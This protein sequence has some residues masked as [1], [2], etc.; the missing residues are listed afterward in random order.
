MGSPVHLDIPPLHSLCSSEYA[1][2]RGHTASH[3]LQ[4][5]VELIAQH[6]YIHLRIHDPNVVLEQGNLGGIQ[7]MGRCEYDVEWDVVKDAEVGSES[8][9]DE[10]TACC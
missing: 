10:G 8:S 9:G 7:G 1:Y 3:N 2:Y 5:V 4:A 6:E